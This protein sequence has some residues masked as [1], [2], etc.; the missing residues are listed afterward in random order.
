MTFLWLDMLWLLGVVPLLVLLYVFLLRR[1]KKL[2]ARY[3][4]L[5]MVRQAMGTGATLR[6]E[7]AFAWMVHHGEPR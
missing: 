4:N 5:S 1:K 3:A 2:A 7:L 6:F